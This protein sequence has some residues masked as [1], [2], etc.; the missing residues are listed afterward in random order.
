MALFFSGLFSVLTPLP[1]LFYAI[2]KKRGRPLQSHDMLRLLW[3]DLQPV[4]EVAFP[5]FIIVLL[6]YVAGLLPLSS[7]YKNYPHFSWVLSIPGMTLL[8]F[9]PG[10]FVI[11]VGVVYFVFFLGVAFV[12]MHLFSKENVFEHDLPPDST[13]NRHFSP[14]IKKGMIHALPRHFSLILGG[15]T[16]IFFSAAIGFYGLLALFKGLSPVAWIRGYYAKILEEFLA[17]NFKGG[18]TIDQLAF[19][20]ENFQAFVSTLT[21]FS[22]AF[23]FCF[24]T[25]VVV[26]NLFFA[27]WLFGPINNNFQEMRLNCWKIDFNW[28][29]VVISGL[30]V[31]LLN[32]FF[33]RQPILYAFSANVLF[34]LVFIYFLQGM[35][36]I[37]YYMTKR[38]KGLLIKIAVYGLILLLFH[39]ISL[40]VSGLGFF[41]SWFDFRGLSRKEL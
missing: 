36:V 13:E 12:L 24:M 23:L 32:A 3:G 38:S 31:V 20:K 37:S 1:L 14:F 9:F 19:L 26:I 25:F 28:V 34:V 8:G 4:L 16:G 27:T 6:V 10:D 17:L 11:L 18:L 5:S 29:W 40:V 35:A 41:D 2:K 21:L 30:F 7:F 39:S 15:G 22:P 33:I